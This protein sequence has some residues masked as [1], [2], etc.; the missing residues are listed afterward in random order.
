MND[1]KIIAALL[2][3]QTI[4]QAAK[5]SGVSESTIYNKMK[6]KTFSR[7]LRDQR[8]ILLVETMNAVQ[9]RVSEAVEVIAELMHN[10]EVSANVR[11]SA[12]ESIIKN[13]ETMSDRVQKNEHHIECDDIA[14]SITE[15]LFH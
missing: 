3:N 10:T 2:S 13:A 7:Q 4:R 14:D 9:L 6:D 8:H 11:L 1:E 5:A 12:A 15:S